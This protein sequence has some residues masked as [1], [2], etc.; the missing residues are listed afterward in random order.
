MDILEQH[1]ISIF[2]VKEYAKQETSVSYTY[3][4]LSPWFS[5]LTLKMEGMSVEFQKTT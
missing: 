2:E 3:H 4:Q 5:S 1:I